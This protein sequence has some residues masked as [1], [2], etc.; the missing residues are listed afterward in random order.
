M[1]RAEHKQRE[2]N[3][4]A[5]NTVTRC[6]RLV[7][8]GHDS[9]LSGNDFR[10]DCLLSQPLRIFRVRVL[11][12]GC[13]LAGFLLLAACLVEPLWSGTRAK[14][15]ENLFL[16]LADT[17]HSLSIKDDTEQ[18]SRSEQLKKLLSENNS[19]WQT[20]L[21]QDFDVRTYQIGERLELLENVNEIENTTSHSQILSSLR[22]INERF[23]NRPLAGVLLLSD[24]NATDF[25]E[26]FSAKNLPP[27]YPVVLGQSKNLHD[28]ALSNV[29]VTQTTFE[30]SPVTMTADVKATGFPETVV[31]AEVID[32]SGKVVK[33]DTEEN[34]RD[35]RTDTRIPVPTSSCQT[36]NE[37]LHF[38][39]AS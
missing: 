27:I 23:H 28:F 35:R 32:E 14:P 39:S 11:G 2:K 25:T 12:A 13:K 5:R 17:S 9:L 1:A 24:G 19:R 31:H 37:L 18:P 26:Q 29:S 30:D 38:E 21:R 7:M 16:I 15:G 36:W 10:R 4:D 8:A 33:S 3:N 6:S 22:T 20:R 34:R